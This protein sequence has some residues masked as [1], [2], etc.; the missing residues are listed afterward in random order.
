MTDENTEN[1]YKR[2]LS[3]ITDENIEE[4]IESIDILVQSMNTV[5]EKLDNSQ[6]AECLIG[7]LLKYFDS[8]AVLIGVKL[9]KEK[10]QTIKTG[11]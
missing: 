6:F 1:I 3:N 2:Y 5:K 11:Y 10:S 9:Q 7:S 8:E 4:K